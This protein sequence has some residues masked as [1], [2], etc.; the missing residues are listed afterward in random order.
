MRNSQNY[1]KGGRVNAFWM[2]LSGRGKQP[3]LERRGRLWV[4]LDQRCDQNHSGKLGGPL[5]CCQDGDSASLGG[6]KEETCWF[7]LCVYVNEAFE[8]TEKQKYQ[9][10]GLPEEEPSS[11]RQKPRTDPCSEWVDKQ[12]ISCSLQLKQ[13]YSENTGNLHQELAQI[14]APVI[15][16]H[17][18]TSQVPTDT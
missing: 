1:L 4:H 11:R 9:F 18:V 5:T 12:I 3:Y 15:G 16:W 13:I 17:F 14:L 8:R 7:C 2:E 6:D 10:S